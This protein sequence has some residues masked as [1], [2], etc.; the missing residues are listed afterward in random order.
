[1]HWFASLD[2]WGQP[3]RMFDLNLG[4]FKGG[5]RPIDLYWR[6]A[7]GITG[8]KMPAHYPTLDADEIWDVV[9]FV[10][11]LPYDPKLL[12]GTT[13]V[14]TTPAKPAVAQR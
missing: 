10:L 14:I 5:R 11:E 8:A 13:P 9:N 6:I 12:E 7:K 2:D 4:L 1:M 3:I